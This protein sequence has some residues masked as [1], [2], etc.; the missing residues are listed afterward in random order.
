MTRPIPLLPT[1]LAFVVT[2]M[3]TWATP[4]VLFVR[5]GAGTG[6]FLEGGADEQLAD[7]SDY[8][9][10]GGNHGW[11][12]LADWLRENDF[13]LHQME[14]GPASNNTP[15]P[16]G[17]LDLSTYDIIVLGSNNADYLPEGESRHVDAIE[18]WVKAGGGLLVISDANFGRNWGDAP[19]SDQQFLDR[20][21]WVMNQDQGTYALN[22][23]AND[24]LVPD[25]PIL[26]GVRSFDGEGVSPIMVPDE[27][28]PG[29]NTTIIARARGTTRINNRYG[30]GSSRQTTTADGSLVIAEVEEGRV[31]GHFDRNTFFNRNGAGTDLNRLDNQTYA[32]NLFRWLA[33]GGGGLEVTIDEPTA[34]TLT[35]ASLEEAVT[36][37]AT[38]SLFGT[39]LSIFDPAAF[40]WSLIDGPGEANL[41]K[42]TNSK[43]T[44]TFSE[45]GLYNLRVQA[46]HR[47]RSTERV[48][49]IEVQ[50]GEEDFLTKAF[51]SKTPRPLLEKVDLDGLVHWQ[52]SYSLIAPADLSFHLEYSTDLRTWTDKESDPSIL[53]DETL[54]FT[55]PVAESKAGFFRV[56]V[57][58]P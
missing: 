24:F 19:D 22:R 40:Q 56:R 51:G 21:G 14:E 57:A 1:L 30:Q 52:L 25:H 49:P 26:E 7:I 4:S 2:A 15:V 33:Y 44:V 20:F 11:G 36:L 48:F 43:T 8:S 47:N 27:K 53:S 31:A 28:V 12:E 9:T 32:L 13:E 46:T 38:A 58:S 6:G 5:G 50:F 17:D 23:T 29:V 42:P 3:G 54:T 39:K 37:S 45:P 16:F 34:T 55:L 41:A 35:L 10:R 18:S